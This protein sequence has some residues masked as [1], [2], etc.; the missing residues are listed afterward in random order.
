MLIFSVVCTILY[1][2]T[3]IGA[4]FI[5]YLVSLYNQ[6]SDITKIALYAFL[7]GG[8]INLCG[9]LFGF[10]SVYGFKND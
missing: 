10:Y 9:C 7:T 5:Q 1:L 6:R 8:P 3:I 4:C 2:W